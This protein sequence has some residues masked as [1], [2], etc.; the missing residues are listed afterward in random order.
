MIMENGI[1]NHMKCCLN[2]ARLNLPPAEIAGIH[3]NGCMERFKKWGVP[4]EKLKH[5]HCGQWMEVRLSDEDY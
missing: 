5:G 4:E 2:C 3:M 1:P